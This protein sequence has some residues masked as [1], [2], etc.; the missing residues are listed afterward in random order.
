MTF[1]IAL[2]ERCEEWINIDGGKYDGRCVS[3]SKSIF[4]KL[5]NYFNTDNIKV[6]QE[7]GG[8]IVGYVTFVYIQGN[9]MYMTLN[10]QDSADKEL[11]NNGF[12]HIG[13]P[14]TLPNGALIIEEIKTNRYS[15]KDIQ[16]TALPYIYI[17]VAKK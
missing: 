11:F 16:S 13:I 17:Y 2:K 10:I 8:T 5:C 1:T 6:A 9:T 14:G 4:S 7:L 12:Y 3:F 15:I